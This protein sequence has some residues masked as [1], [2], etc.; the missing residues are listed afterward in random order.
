MYRWQD[1][2]SIDKIPIQWKRMLNLFFKKPGKTFQRITSIISS[3]L[4][5]KT[6]CLR[7]YMYDRL[8]ICNW[9]NYDMGEGRRWLWDLQQQHTSHERR[10]RIKKGTA[11]PTKTFMSYFSMFMSLSLQKQ[12]VEGLST[13]I[14]RDGKDLYRATPDVTGAFGVLRHNPKD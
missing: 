6:E 1:A 12:N 4:T 2:S 5:C 11:K 9:G 7:M 3:E 10:R 13:L 14:L 8:G